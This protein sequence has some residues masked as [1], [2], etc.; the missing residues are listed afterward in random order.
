MLNRGL[1]GWT[2]YL[3]LLV[4]FSLV[5]GAMIQVQSKVPAKASCTSVRCTCV[6]LHLEIIIIMSAIFR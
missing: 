5:Q 1:S 4:F 3:L 2:T 6:S